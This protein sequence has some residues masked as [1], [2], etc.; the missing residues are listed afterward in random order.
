MIQKIILKNFS[1]IGISFL[2]VFLVSACSREIDYEWTTTSKITF[3]NETTSTIFVKG[4]DCKSSNILPNKT[5]IYQHVQVHPGTSL[6][7]KPNINNFEIFIPCTFFYGN[8]EK[9][10]SEVQGIDNYEY[11]K[12]TRSLEFE[13]TFRFTEERKSMAKD[14]N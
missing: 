2:I 6:N 11:K 9:C 5:L 12:E 3:I 8:T 4:N 10:E 13:F 14:C 1:T 7:D